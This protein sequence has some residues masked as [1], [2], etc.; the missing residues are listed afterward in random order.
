[1]NVVERG[2]C[3]FYGDLRYVQASFKRGDNVTTLSKEQFG[4][5]DNSPEV[6]EIAYVSRRVRILI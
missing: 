5:K 4:I 1:M 2:I 3:M 6:I